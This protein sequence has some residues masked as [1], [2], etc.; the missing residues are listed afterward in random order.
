[1]RGAYRGDVVT[2]SYGVDSVRGII[3]AVEGDR[4]KVQ[5]GRDWT[6]LFVSDLN[7][8]G[9]SLTKTPRTEHGWRKLG[10]KWQF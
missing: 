4:A 3:R 9:D 2:W 10:E 7:W 6:W 5:I 8:T 1:M